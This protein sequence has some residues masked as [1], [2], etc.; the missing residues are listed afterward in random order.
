[1]VSSIN[2]DRCRHLDLAVLSLPA[3][4]AWVKVNWLCWPLAGVMHSAS[5]G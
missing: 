4:P 5:H 2:C 3:A 1:M